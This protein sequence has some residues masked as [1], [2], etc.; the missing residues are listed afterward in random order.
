[1]KK[2]LKLVNKHYFNYV[3]AY[4]TLFN[5]CF[6]IRTS[7]VHTKNILAEFEQTLIH[8]L[9]LNP[10]NYITYYAKKTSKIIFTKTKK[11]LLVVMSSYYRFR[12][13][14]LLHL[15]VK[16]H[17]NAY[18]S[19]LKNCDN[20]LIC[21]NYGCC[22]KKSGFIFNNL[23]KKRM[24]QLLAIDAVIL[25]LHLVLLY[26]NAVFVYCFYNKPQ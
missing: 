1:M 19:K 8:S 23:Q 3:G 6:K 12:T 14:M 20:Q 26:I 9:I 11:T 18:R 15:Y 17:F 22:L 13:F 25:C 2:S 5:F 7:S 10:H 16:V 21:V 24:L 4:L